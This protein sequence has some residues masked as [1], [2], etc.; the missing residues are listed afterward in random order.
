MRTSAVSSTSTMVVLAAAVRFG[1]VEVRA[2]WLEHIRPS[3][4]DATGSGYHT[5]LY[6][7]Q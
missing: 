4:A 7:D 5:A 2:R 3:D 6:A 1:V